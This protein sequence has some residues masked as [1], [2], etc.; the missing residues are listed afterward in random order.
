MCPELV[1]ALADLPLPDHQGV[2]LPRDR[3][4]G[5]VAVH[6]DIESYHLLQLIIVAEGL[7]HSADSLRLAARALD[8]LPLVGPAVI[9]RR[10]L[11]GDCC[12][13]GGIRRRFFLRVKK[14]FRNTIPY[15]YIYTVVVLLGKRF[16]KN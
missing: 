16:Q 12:F 10:N 2:E 9:R 15:R 4:A 14:S 7:L 6:S 11:P 1:P 8:D 3:R 5:A 13:S